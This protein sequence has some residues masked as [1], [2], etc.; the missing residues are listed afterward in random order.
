MFLEF[1]QGM[2]LPKKDSDSSKSNNSTMK[3][4]SDGVETKMQ[5]NSPPSGASKNIGEKLSMSSLELS[6]K[7]Q[8]TASELFNALSVSEVREKCLTMS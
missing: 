5:M 7:F 6:E 8:C 4:L 2:I 3:S 1:T